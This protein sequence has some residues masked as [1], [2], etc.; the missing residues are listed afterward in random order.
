MTMLLDDLDDNY[1]ACGFCAQPVHETFKFSDVLLDFLE[2]YLDVK[3]SSLPTRVCA[4]CFKGTKVT[5]LMTTS[6]KET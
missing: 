4:T 3:G 5:F 1:K 2:Y 6:F